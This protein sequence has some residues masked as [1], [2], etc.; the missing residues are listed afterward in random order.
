MIE[1]LQDMPAGDEI[2]FVEVIGSD[3]EG[4]GPGGQLAD[5]K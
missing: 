2:R 3:Y 4:F 5:V 1:V